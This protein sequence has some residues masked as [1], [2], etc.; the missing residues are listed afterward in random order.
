MKPIRNRRKPFRAGNR[1]QILR[2]DIN[3]GARKR[4]RFGYITKIDGA[5]HYV[6]PLWWKEG[7][8]LELYETEIRHAPLKKKG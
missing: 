5:Y 7:E 8:V 6:R 3:W 2:K 1:V 4:Q